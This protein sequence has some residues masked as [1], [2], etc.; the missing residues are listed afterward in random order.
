[1]VNSRV[2]VCASLPLLAKIARAKVSDMTNS[3]ARTYELAEITRMQN[4]D[5]VNSRVCAH[6]SLP[7]FAKVEHTKFA[8]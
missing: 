1:M 8:T 4:C 6:A 3:R 7:L 5:M 2:R